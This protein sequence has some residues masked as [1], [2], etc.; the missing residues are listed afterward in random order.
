M[1][2]LNNKPDLH[3]PKA[4]LDEIAALIRKNH[5]R[6]ILPYTETFLIKSL[7]KRLAATSI[8]TAAAYVRHLACNGAEAEAFIHSLSVGYSEF[9]RDPLVFA[10]LGQVI[11]PGIIQE[12][13]ASGRVEVR[14]WSAGCASGQEAWSVAILLD[15]LAAA[16]NHPIHFW[17]IAT[18]VSE[19]LLAL[20]RRGEYTSAE[21]KNV[22][23]KYIESCFSRQGDMYRIVE[24]I[25]TRVDFSIFDLLDEHSFCPPA[26]IF[27]NFDLV[28]CCNLIF[29]FRPTIREAILA[30]LHRCLA[31]KGYLA[32]GETER[33][34]VEER[35]DFRLVAPPAAI[36][37][38]R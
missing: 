27:G 13:N 3:W 26:S 2:Q 32:T 34:I 38:K 28:L 35:R 20:A 14:V 36:F 29:Y 25:R 16:R 6:D 31:S 33:A 5:N 11:L 9:F 8:A 7:E 19:T 37:R 1:T 12:Q 22:P 10:L 23:L 15:Q 18:D 17:I 24:R 30:K 21:I 4:T